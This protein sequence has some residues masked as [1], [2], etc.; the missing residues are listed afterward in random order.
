MEIKFLL[1]ENR[2]TFLKA[3]DMEQAG[4]KETLRSPLIVIILR[5]NEVL[6]Y[7]GWPYFIS[8]QTTCATIIKETFLYVI[9]NNNCVSFFI[10]FFL[11]FSFFSLVYLY[12]SRKCYIFKNYF[13]ILVFKFYLSLYLCAL[14]MLISLCLYFS[15]YV[16]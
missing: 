6:L 3:N 10:F 11:F 4:I 13:Y 8:N 12:L 1:F 7:Q 15:F 5:E 9:H 14:F 16:C 2:W